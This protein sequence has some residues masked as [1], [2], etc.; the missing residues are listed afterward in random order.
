MT[1][2]FCKFEGACFQVASYNGI[3]EFAFKF[4]V[5][6]TAVELD[7][8]SYVANND[9]VLEVFYISY[10]RLETDTFDHLFQKTYEVKTLFSVAYK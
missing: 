6:C 8:N 3:L 1:F 5:N 7:P 10:H 9:V 2:I 4:E